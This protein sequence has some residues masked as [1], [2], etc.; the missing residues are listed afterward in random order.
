MHLF[1][2]ITLFPDFFNSPL[3]S[4]LLGRAIRDRIIKVNIIDLRGFSTNKYHSCDDYPYGGGTGMVLQAGPLFKAIESVKTIR[5]KMLLT[6]PSGRMLNQELVK[7]LSGENDICIICGHYEG[8]DQRVID[9][10]IDYEI[11]IGDYIISGGEYGAL[12]ILDS[13][14]RYVPGFMSNPESLVQESF[15][16]NLL[17]YPQYSRPDEIDGWEVPDI[18]LSGNHEKIREWRTSKAIEKTMKIRPDLYNKYLNRKT[19]NLKKKEK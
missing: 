14:S 18:L 5:T 11:S 8:V 9:R 4:S 13:I 19:Q 2:I 15:E 1:N 17:E 3:Q 7:E 10:Y 12:I 6:S 16:D